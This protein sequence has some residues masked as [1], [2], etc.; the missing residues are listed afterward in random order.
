[1]DLKTLEVSGFVSTGRQP[2]GL[3]WVP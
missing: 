3:A 2:D 1:V